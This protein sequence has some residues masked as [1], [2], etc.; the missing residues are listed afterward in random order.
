MS[1]IKTG[2]QRHNAD[3]LAGAVIETELMAL[4]GMS[5]SELRKAWIEHLG[6][7]PP[8]V[9]SQ[10]VLR[11]MLAWQIQARMFGGLDTPTERKLD[12]IAAMLERDGTYEPRLRRDLSLGVIV[13]REWKGEV[14]KVTVIAGGFAY[15]G[16]QYRSLSEIA[17]AI[18]GTRWSG[19]RFFGLEQKQGRK[20]KPRQLP[21]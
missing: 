21:S 3:P 20:H 19:P 8:R 4:A 2:R 13:T 14:H 6:T 1:G 12:E 17:R 5:V 16:K 11:S 15:A 18:T 9:R 7:E 10:H